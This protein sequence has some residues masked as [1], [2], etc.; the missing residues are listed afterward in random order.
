[1]SL[2]EMIAECIRI[3]PGHKAFALFYMG[4]GEWEAHIGNTCC[5]VMLGEAAAEFE[6]RSATPELAVSALLDSLRGISEA[7]ESLSQMSDGTTWNGEGLPP[8]GTVCEYNLTAG[9]W[10]VCEIRYVLDNDK[11]PD[12][13]GWI[14]VIWCPHL[15]KEQ[16]ARAGGVSFRPIRTPVHIAAEEALRDIELLYSEGGPAA[17]YDAGYRKQEAP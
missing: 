5:S 1:M 9:P 16:V 11:D 6:E 7:A 13:D 2:S 4:P 17:V 3:K 8:V 14:A 12:A 15:G 10:F